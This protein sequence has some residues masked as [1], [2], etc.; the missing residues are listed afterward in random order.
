MPLQIISFLIVFFSINVAGQTIDRE[1]VS[2]SGNVEYFPVG[3]VSISS[4][5]GEV[6][7]SQFSEYNFYLSQ[8]QQQS[9]SF[10][11]LGTRVVGESKL[12]IYPTITYGKIFIDSEEDILNVQVYNSSGQV[13]TEEQSVLELNISSEAAGIYYVMIATAEKVFTQKVILVK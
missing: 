4:S 13:V 7:I 3:S 2:N 9:S 11:T 8:G 10:I 5:L 12:E 6:F 1:L